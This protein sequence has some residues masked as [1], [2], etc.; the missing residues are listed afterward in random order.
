MGCKTKEDFKTIEGCLPRL[1]APNTFTPNDDTFNDT[2]EVK[3]A[4]IKN[5][6]LT[7][8]N[9]WGET[10]FESKDPEIRWNGKVSGK[11]TPVGVYAYLVTYESEDFPDKGI[12]KERGT[13]TVLR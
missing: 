13:I 7:V 10:I 3:Y 12:I 6:Q 11:A 8:Y 5:Y 1:F 2:F 4:H 9:R